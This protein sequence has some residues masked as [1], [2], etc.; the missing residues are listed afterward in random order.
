M[1]MNTS[2]Q[3]KRRPEYHPFVSRTH[4]MT[5]GAPDHMSKLI[6]A[7]FVYFSN[8][9]REKLV[10]KLCV[11]RYTTKELYHPAS[12]QK[13]S[14][15]NSSGFFSFSIKHILKLEQKSCMQLSFSDTFYYDL[16]HNLARNIVLNKT[17]NTLRRQFFI[18]Q[19]PQNV[20]LMIHC[21][22]NFRNLSIHPYGLVA[23]DVYA[24]TES[25]DSHGWMA[26]VMLVNNFCTG[27]TYHPQNKRWIRFLFYKHETI[28]DILCNLL[29]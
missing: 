27:V 1:I 13:N 26:L 3:S 29:K 12:G 5:M 9:V 28:K 7:Y 24:T 8:S 4:S 22:S 14:S 17:F 23:P 6:I 11:K 19:D 25:F 21:D 15:G 10:Q 16:Y 20:H 2:T 18:E